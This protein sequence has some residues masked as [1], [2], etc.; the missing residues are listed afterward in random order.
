[1]FVSGADST[2]VLRVFRSKLR[3]EE[4]LLHFAENLCTIATYTYIYIEYSN[5][6]L[7]VCI[8]GADVICVAAFVVPAMKGLRC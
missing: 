5:A 2:A 8:Q 1:M 4:H 3:H 6:Q 7:I